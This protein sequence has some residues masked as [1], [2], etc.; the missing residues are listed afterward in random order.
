MSLD[1]SF[2]VRSFMKIGPQLWPGS[3]SLSGFAITLIERVG[4]MFA[5]QV[6]HEHQFECPDPL[7]RIQL[8]RLR[9]QYSF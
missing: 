2:K 8:A 6:A 9:V 1:V 5:R 4:T 3:I 7:L